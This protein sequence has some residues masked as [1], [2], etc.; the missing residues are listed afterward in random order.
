M[1][2]RNLSRAKNPILLVEDNINDVFLMQRAFQKA[3]VSHP[4]MAVASKQQALDYLA[5]SG[6]YTDRKM[7]PNPL[8]VLLD[9]MLPDGTGFDIL[10][11]IR[12]GSLS[13]SIPVIV[14]TSCCETPD[15][16]K[17]YR[18]GANSYLVK[19]ASSRQMANIVKTFS[20]YWLRLNKRI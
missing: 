15:I 10:Q 17:A 2:R 3:D 14:L 13:P 4:L 20:D 7:F 11:W 16:Q 6:D 9:L 18:L 5:G 1:I 8:L 19:P 12:Q